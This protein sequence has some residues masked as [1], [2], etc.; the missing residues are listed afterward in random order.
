MKT[1]EKT[2]G[3]ETWIENN[4]KYCLKLI[5]CEDR[6]WSS[7]GDFHHHPIKDETFVVLKGELLLD[8]EGS[9][10][11][12]KSWDKQRIRPGVNHRFRSIGSSCTFLEVSTPHS[13]E[14][15]VRVP[16]E[17]VVKWNGDLLVDKG[18]GLC[19]SCEIATGL[20]GGF[21]EM[22]GYGSARQRYCPVRT[23]A[24]HFHDLTEC[25]FYKEDKR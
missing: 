9:D 3:N 23:I 20:E 5:I 16:Y 18:K 10:R 13:D 1:V 17:E 12:L 22:S 14:D 2:W 21:A 8:I 4:E 7:E 24:I 11:I 19:S 15:V 25:E 6:K